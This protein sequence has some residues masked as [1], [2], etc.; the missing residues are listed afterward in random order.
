MRPLIFFEVQLESWL[1]CGVGEL[2][3]LCVGNLYAT[4]FVAQISCE[5][6]RVHEAE[7]ER[8][9]RAEQFPGQRKWRAQK[10]RIKS[11]LYPMYETGGNGSA[12]AVTNF[13]SSL[14]ALC[15]WARPGAD[16]DPPWGNHEAGSST[17]G[18]MGH[19][20]TSTWHA[21]REMCTSMRGWSTLAPACWKS[22]L[23][24]ATSIASNGQSSFRAR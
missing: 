23:I 7:G 22:L 13:L 9:R 11:P 19:Q 8:D 15:E 3:C 4:F 6:R 24:G 21:H 18:K 14:S 16:T 20:G 1:K 17:T 12:I 5:A 10:A 2:R